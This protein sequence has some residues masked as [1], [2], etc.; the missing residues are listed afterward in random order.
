MRNEPLG[1]GQNT[2]SKN[3]EEKMNKSKILL[4]FDSF[5]AFFQPAAPPSKGG[6]KDGNDKDK[7]GGKG[8]TL[9]LDSKGVE[10][11]DNVKPVSFFYQV[12]NLFNGRLLSP[13]EAFFA[14]R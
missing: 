3:L 6:G 4:F 14:P 13:K 10:F 8:D 7:G 5:F 12:A 2:R 11:I 1:M 9:K